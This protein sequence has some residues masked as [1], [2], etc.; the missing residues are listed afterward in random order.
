MTEVREYEVVENWSES[1]LKSHKKSD[2][3]VIH[4]MK[5]VKEKIQDSRWMEQRYNNGL[6]SH[7]VMKFIENEEYAENSN[8]PGECVSRSLVQEI[9]R[10]YAENTSFIERTDL[11]KETRSSFP[12][13]NV[14]S[15]IGYEYKKPEELEE[16]KSR[17]E[18]LRQKMIDDG[19]TKI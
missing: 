13:E 11:D 6:T 12:G 15:C 2:D 4:V 9:L 17:K 7:S 16:E 8:L 10:E 1:Q 5:I 18:E 14:T 3:F 19:I